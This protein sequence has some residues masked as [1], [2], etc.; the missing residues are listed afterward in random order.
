MTD[1]EL[2]CKGQSEMSI[3]TLRTAIS[4]LVIHGFHFARLFSQGIA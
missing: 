1:L 4:Q 3:A 2:H